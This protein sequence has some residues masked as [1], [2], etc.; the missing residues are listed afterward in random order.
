MLV[1]LG[2]LGKLYPL[3]EAFLIEQ[4]I[5]IYIFQAVSEAISWDADRSGGGLGGFFVVR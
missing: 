5:L 2:V 1:F 3:T 4:R